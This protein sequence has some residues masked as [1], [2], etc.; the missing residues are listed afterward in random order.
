MKV[1]ETDPYILSYCEQPLKI[2]F[3]WG[4]RPYSY[5][6]DILSTNVSSQSTL[7]EVK[8]EEVLKK[9][10]GRLAVKF[11]AAKEY[12]LER[13]WTFKIVTEAV[14]KSP[15]YQRADLLWPHLMNPNIDENHAE[16]IFR[17][18]SD[19]GVLRLADLVEKD[20]WA[21]PSYCA[22]LHLIGKGWLVESSSGIFEPSTHIRV[23]TDHG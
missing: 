4:G 2:E 15:E 20:G 5:T 23:F 1:L 22:L 10:D 7:Y 8:P 18:V 21:D 12:C 16:T 9:D 6:P 13:G 3:K 11:D 17:R 14:R 19:A